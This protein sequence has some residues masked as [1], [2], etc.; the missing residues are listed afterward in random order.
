VGQLARALAHLALAR[1]TTGDDAAATAL[2]AHAEAEMAGIGEGARRDRARTRV[3]EIL[4]AAGDT[5]RA[6]AVAAG[7]EGA[8]G[9]VR[10]FAAAAA[11][12]PTEDRAW[13]LLARAEADL[14]LVADER[15]H[16]ALT[17]RLAAAAVD[18]LARCP[19]GDRNGPR[20]SW[21][22]GVVAG[23]LTSDSW[24]DAVPALSRLDRRA[25]DAVVAWL[26]SRLGG[27]ITATA[28]M[29]LNSSSTTGSTSGSLV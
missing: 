14:A 28:G 20:R 27:P 1:E 4:A 13:A 11:C 15:E 29:H 7:I 25:F 9:R 26:V 2:L 12:A 8:A 5:A 6:E 23:L 21:L 19:E 22:T 16:G 24:I 17:G 10:A 3:A 18:V